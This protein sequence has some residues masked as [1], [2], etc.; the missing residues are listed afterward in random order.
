V[1]ARIW[2][3]YTKPEPANA[4]GTTLKPELLPGILWESID[5]KSAHYEI[6]SM[7]RPSEL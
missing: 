7:Q 6:R 4:Y 2:Y 1:I 3:G 5:A